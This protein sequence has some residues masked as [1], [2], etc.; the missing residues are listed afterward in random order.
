VPA[1]V[2]VDVAIFQTSDASVPNVV[3][4]RVPLDQTLSGIVEAREVDAVSTVASTWVSIVDIAEVIWVFVLALML[5]ARDVDAAK[6]VAFVFALTLVPFTVIAEAMD[7]DALLVFAFILDASEVD[8]ASIEAFVF[9]LT[10]V[11]PTVIAE[12]IDDDALLVLAL[13]AVVPAV[14]AEAIDEDALFVFALTFEVSVVIALAID[15]DAV[16][17]SDWSASEPDERVPAVRVRLPKLQT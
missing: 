14:I 1:V 5:V 10:L 17:T 6:T 15:E 16:V 11:L 2:R 4:E 9:A 12:A 3:R 8:A 13:T 7:D